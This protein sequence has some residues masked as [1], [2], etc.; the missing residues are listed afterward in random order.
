MLGALCT[1]HLLDHFWVMPLGCGPP[2]QAIGLIQIMERTQR[3]ATK[4]I[5]KLPFLTEISYTSRL[6]TLHLLPLTYWH[7]Y[8]DLVLFY[9]M[10]NGLVNVNPS[11]LPTVRRVRQT[12]S[13]S[14]NAT[15]YNE[16]KCKTTTYQKFFVRTTRIWN[17]LSSELN[18]NC[19]SVN[20]LK[21]ALQE[22]YFAALYLYDADD[23][24]LYKTICLKCNSCRS[25]ARPVT[26]C[27]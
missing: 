20:S 15:K 25:L 24:R 13:Y 6:I 17:C 10:N 26:C 27:N 12:R 7:E 14:V 4:Y 3:R 22:Y 11:L 21:S 18:L 19:S 16:H 9:K 2:M 8:L 1:L 5:L 23:P